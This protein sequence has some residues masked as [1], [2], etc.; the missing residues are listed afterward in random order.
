MLEVTFSA[1]VIEICP[2]TV[3]NNARIDLSLVDLL[4]LQTFLSKL[5]IRNWSNSIF[6]KMLFECTTLEIF[7]L[8]SVM[9][10]VYVVT[11]SFI[12]SVYSCFLASVPSPLHTA[13]VACSMISS[14]CTVSD[15]SCR[16]WRTGSEAM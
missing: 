11:G 2:P 13:I 5:H 15:D 10:P 7:Y 1:Y 12:H 4:H 3:N 16:R 8:C 9:Y 6:P 14:T